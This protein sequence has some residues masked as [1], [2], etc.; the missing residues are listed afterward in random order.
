MHEWKIPDHL[1]CPIGLELMNDPVICNDGYTYERENILA[2]SHGISPMTRQPINKSILIPNRAIVDAVAKFLKNKQE[3]KKIN[4]WLYIIKFL[5]IIKNARIIK[6]IIINGD[7]IIKFFK[8]YIKTDYHIKKHHE[9][10]FEKFEREQIKK[11]QTIR[12]AIHQEQEEKLKKQKE[13]QE[14]IQLKRLVYYFNSKMPSLLGSFISNSQNGN[15]FIGRGYIMSTKIKTTLADI[16]RIKKL[17]INKLYDIYKKLNDELIW[18]KKYV[19]GYGSQHPYVDY[20]FDHYINNLD[21]LILRTK[22][23]IKYA[24]CIH[25]R[26]HLSICMHVEEL[27]ELERLKYMNKPR[28]YYYVNFEESELKYQIL[29]QQIPFNSSSSLP[30]IRWHFAQEKII[31]SIGQ[32]LTSII[33]NSTIAKYNISGSW[34][35]QPETCHILSSFPETI[36]SKRKRWDSHM[37]DCV[38]SSFFEKEDYIEL[39]N[40][41]KIAIEIIEFTRPEIICDNIVKLVEA[42]KQRQEEVETKAI[43]ALEMPFEWQIAGF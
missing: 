29:F 10:L 34:S 4:M 1:I 38:Y 3:R 23:S 8:N 6:N 7:I 27:N 35:R 14:N 15:G 13:R 40:L 17:P 24:D 39:I 11:E 9:S 43:A 37:A 42:E 21:S 33:G 18:I 22:E 41:A 20:V 19:F 16:L 30:A 2:L 32:T 26:H 25:D 36:I 5:N 12:E 31:Q 28:E